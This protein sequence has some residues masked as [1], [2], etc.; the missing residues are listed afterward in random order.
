MRKCGNCKKRCFAGWGG[1][2]ESC[3]DYEMTGS[4]A[5]EIET[6]KD[7]GNYEEGTPACL[8]DIQFYSSG[9]NIDETQF[10]TH[11]E[12]DLAELWWEFCKDNNL[13]TVV[14]GKADYESGVIVKTKD[15]EVI[16]ITY[17][18]ERRWKHRS[19][20]IEFFKKGVIECEGAERDRYI[21]VL[22][23]LEEMKSVC[24]DNGGF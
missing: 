12:H 1:M 19:E 24:T 6:A 9:G 8:E 18:Q 20:A 21:N 16:T 3:L 22:I 14:K 11:N 5:E 7:C 23:D 13:I 15:Y 2:L 17:N 10:D 4:E